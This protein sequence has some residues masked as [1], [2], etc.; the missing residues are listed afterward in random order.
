K[1]TKHERWA[2]E[3]WCKYGTTD[4]R[5]KQEQATKKWKTFTAE[6]TSY[7]MIFDAA[8]KDGWPNPNSAAAVDNR[9]VI[10]VD[11][12]PLHELAHKAQDALVALPARFYVQGPQLVRPVSEQDKGSE[13]QVVTV[14]R[15][16]RVTHNVMLV[17]LSR[18][19]N[20]VKFD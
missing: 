17:Y 8:Q 19:A 20:F 14:A 9:P 10:A 1:G 18:S 2:F 3:L 5:F 11:K 7:V 4:D 13:G 12:A 15:L 6:R 16:A